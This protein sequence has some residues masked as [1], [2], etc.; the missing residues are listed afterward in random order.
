[1]YFNLFKNLKTTLAVKKIKKTEKRL[2]L[3]KVQMSK[4]KGGISSGGGDQMLL[5]DGN[6]TVL[7]KTLDTLDVTVKN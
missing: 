5:N 3:N 4:I 2:S 6:D 7:D 1:M